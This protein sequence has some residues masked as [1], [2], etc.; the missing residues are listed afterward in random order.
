VLGALVV[1]V[2]L[3]RSGWAAAAQPLSLVKGGKPQAVI[4]IQGTIAERCELRD[5]MTFP[6]KRPLPIAQVA[7]T[8]QSYIARVS[9]AELPIQTT[10]SDGEA[11]AIHVGLTAFAAG[12][13]IPF[14]KYDPDA[15]VL[16]RVGSQVVLVGVDDWGT[17]MAVYAFLERVC[18]VRWF[19]P[20]PLGEV[21][22]KAQD[23]VVGALDVVEE[24]SYL[25]RMMS[26]IFYRSKTDGQ[27]FREAYTWMRRN[28]LRERYEFHHNLN[29]IVKPAAY[30]KEHPDYFPWVGGKRLIPRPGGRADWQPCMS[31]PGVVRLCAQAARAFFDK[32]PGNRSF[33]IGVNDNYGYCECEACLKLNGGVRYAAH[34]K[35]D[36][37]PL[38]FAFANKVCEEVAKTHPDR[39]LGGLIYTA[40]TMTP[41][42]F[43]LHRNFVGY[44][45]SDRSRY[46][47][48]PDFRRKEKEYL[49]SW[50]RKCKCLGLYEWY[51]GSGYEVP[52][53]YPHTMKAVLKDG[54]DLGVRGFYAEAYPNWGLEGPKLYIT[55]RLLWDVEA[56]PDALLDDFCDRFF[57]QAAEPMRQYFSKLEDCWVS[58][59]LRKRE[60]FIHTY[61]RKDRAQL[62]VYP[63][64]DL[65]ACGKHLQQAA[66]LAKDDTEKRRVELFRNCFDVVRYYVER[67]T[68]H[69]RLEVGRDLD[70]LALAE[71]VHNVNAMHHLTLALSRHGAAHLSGND[72]GLHRGTPAWRFRSMEPYYAE[73]GARVATV[74]AEAEKAGRKSLAGCSGAELR[75]AVN[76]RLEALEQQARGAGKPDAMAPAWPELKGRVLRYVQSTTVVPRMDA[77]P[78]IDGTVG[79]AEWKKAAKLAP[80]QLLSGKGPAQYATTVRLGYGDE[81]LYLACVCVEASM[82][83]VLQRYRRRDSSVWQDDAVEFLIQRGGGEPGEFYHFIT[84]S[85]GTFYDAF[86]ADATWNGAPQVAASQDKDRNTWTLEM[87]IPWKD[88]G[89]RPAAGE[90]RRGNFCRDNPEPAAA[91]GRG[92]WSS[93]SPSFA[94][95]NNP[96]Y[97]GLLLFE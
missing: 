94:G 58:Q 1:A 6:G 89:G 84:N 43:D 28:R 88:L 62:K 52:R 23:V 35:R 29:A 34:G 26:G 96:T 82:Q 40:G 73:L 31:N 67:E 22:P 47:F 56:D 11:P 70:G 18:G 3:G 83:H 39:K 76:T 55:C 64:A 10:P 79:A 74:L 49:A 13:K 37:S 87:A 97:F 72:Y 54:Y 48:D 7:Q 78:R 44:I 93:W 14:E 8:L 46:L 30:A 33:S 32:F 71:I 85:L 66:R 95:F 63:L 25:S 5:E 41:P 65:V 15:F 60:P 12:L 19:M 53:Y 9:G 24:P 75:A 36:Y 45:P 86:A 90:L 69:D 77:A 57:G 92:E 4:V 81:C 51:F 50:A 17:E 20:G 42:P 2:A 27:W 61:L 68:L 59:P 91:H 38:Y 21:V 16:R 80:F